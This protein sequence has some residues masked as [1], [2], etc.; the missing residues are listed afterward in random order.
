MT[1]P[2]RY[3]TRVI[4]FLVAV[5]AVVLALIEPLGRAFF[6]N[7]ALNGLIVV[8]LVIG[9]AFSIRQIV[10]LT[11]EVKWIDEYR[12]S[13]SVDDV[14]Q[15][16][17]MLAPMAAMLGEDRQTSLSALSLRTLLDGIAARMDETRDITRYLIGLLIFLGLLGTFWGLLGTIAAIS[18]TIRTLSID[19]PDVSLMFD[20]L[21]EG[22]EAPLSGMGTAFS[23]SLFGLAGS[24]VL[25]FVDLQTGQ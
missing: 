3:L 20:E 5:A 7:P 10:A 15:K 12:K 21:K 23:S 13:D 11:A 4:L 9:V 25:G 18:D 22:L 14:R 19:S 2:Q 24:V 17:V 6:A 8:T 16:P 1:R